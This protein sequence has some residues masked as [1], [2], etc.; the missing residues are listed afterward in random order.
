MYS[1][2]W[3]LV[4]YIYYL[5]YAEKLI[6]KLYS[7]EYKKPKGKAQELAQVAWWVMEQETISSSSGSIG[8]AGTS[9]VCCVSWVLWSTLCVYST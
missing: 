2:M 4:A 9:L 1:Y 6:V 5:G 7:T 3:H 8:S